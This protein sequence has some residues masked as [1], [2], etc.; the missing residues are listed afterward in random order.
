AVDL[1]VDLTYEIAFG[2]QE[3]AEGISQFFFNTDILDEVTID[4]AATLREDFDS[5]KGRVGVFIA[6]FEHGGTDASQF[7]GQYKLNLEQ[8]D[9]AILIGGSLTG[10]GAAVLDIDAAFFPNVDLGTDLINLGVTAEGSVTYDTKIDFEN[11][12]INADDNEI[13]VGINDVAIDL[14]RI[15]NDFIDPMLTRLQDSLRPSAP[16]IDFLTKPIPILSELSELLGQGEITALD[17]AGIGEDDPAYKA[18]MAIDAILSYDGLPSSAL[19]AAQSVFSLE[20]P[21][22]GFDPSV[23]RNRLDEVTENARKLKDDILNIEL[24]DHFQSPQGQAEF[25]RS[26]EWSREFEGTID[27]PFLTDLD[28]LA[29]FLLGDATSELFTFEAAGSIGFEYDVSMPIAPLLNLVQLNA[30]LSV[31]ASLKLAGGY[32]AYGISL[33]SRVADFSSLQALETSIAENQMLLVNGFYMEDHNGTA[34]I[35]GEPEFTDVDAAE[36]SLNVVM[37]G[38]LSGGLSF[39]GLKATV[40]GDVFLDGTLGLDLNDLPNPDSVPELAID[41]QFW[42]DAIS[43][44]WLPS[45]LETPEQW[46]YDGRIR[47]PELN[48]IA[49]ANPLAVVNVDGKLEAGLAAS[50]KVETFG[51]TLVNEQWE[52]LRMTLLDGALFQADDAELIAA[53]T[54]SRLGT[55]VDGELRLFAGETAGQ[56]TDAAPN[57]TNET[58]L[59]RSLG[60]A[61]GGGE[62]LLVIFTP[63]EDVNAYRPVGTDPIDTSDQESYRFIFENV[64]SIRAFTG[65]GNDSITIQ[66]GVQADVTL[67]GGSGD[68]K[69]TVGTAGIATIYGEDGN[70]ILVGSDQADFIY[71]GSGDDYIDGR[72]GDDMIQGDAGNDKVFGGV[73][74]DSIQ[75]G[76]GDDNLDGGIGDDY[77]TGGSGADIL[78]GDLGL[79]TIIGGSGDDTIRYGA[80]LNDPDTRD[81]LVG[82]DGLDNIQIYGT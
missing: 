53:A 52:L 41:P 68:D 6:D 51:I 32:D 77:I 71:G 78:R 9:D 27:L 12:G 28:V 34:G 61:Q 20:M 8:S 69:I 15:Y 21:K 37:T 58:F 80:Y 25:E 66:E 73:G 82:G 43:P 75:G 1:Q 36:V 3:N 24:S 50:V 81:N 62:N 47:V 33:L 30:G 57:A 42:E 64:T 4:Y 60:P 79:D 17:L 35:Q 39:G 11:G 74:N 70:D 72:A 63:H 54:Q 16:A 14:G 23:V 48:T 65:D 18:V 67:H 56:R 38:G 22:Q 59:V 55:V 26:M 76:I 7:N 31:N 10:E 45:L 29:G 2:V 40:G 13:I 49:Q 19:G 46:V 5:G 44:E